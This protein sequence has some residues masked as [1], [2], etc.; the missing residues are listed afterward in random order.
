MLDN[1]ATSKENS[2]S[3]IRFIYYI[4]TS[5]T[6]AVMLYCTVVCQRIGPHSFNQMWR[7]AARENTF[8][9]SAVLNQFSCAF[10]AQFIC[11]RLSPSKEAQDTCTLT[12][13]RE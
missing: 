3:H 4:A 13:P 12:S 2:G 10:G 11:D 8:I 5:Y 9:V 6:G 1:L 7:V